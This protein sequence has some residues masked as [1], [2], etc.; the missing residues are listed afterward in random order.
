MTKLEDSAAR[1][2]VVLLYVVLAG[3]LLIILTMGFMIGDLRDDVNLLY[4]HNHEKSVKFQK[5]EEC[6]VE[7][8]RGYNF[9]NEFC[10]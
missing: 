8:K 10:P 2:H 3:A 9:R 6:L 4:H 5:L 7:N 1:E